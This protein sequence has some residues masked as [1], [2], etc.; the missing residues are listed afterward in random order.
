TIADVRF[1]AIAALAATFW[2]GVAT[3]RLMIHGGGC[4][5][6]HRP[7]PHL[8]ARGARIEVAAP[9]L[10]IQST[11][12]KPGPLT[13][14]DVAA[15]LEA[16]QQAMTDCEDLGWKGPVVVDLTIGPRGW[17]RSADVQPRLAGTRVGRCVEAHV[18]ARRFPPSD[19]GLTTRQLF[20]LY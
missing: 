5:A 19:A 6:R 1:V 12:V 3:L 10:E 16:L 7:A 17:V 15:D 9:R 14:A 4:A 11:P 20:R 8:P 13:R 2:I 18:Y